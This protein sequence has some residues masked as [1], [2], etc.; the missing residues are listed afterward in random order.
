MYSVE[1]PSA[2]E[3]DHKEGWDPVVVEEG[4]AITVGRSGA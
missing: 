4:L 1:D 3:D 2:T